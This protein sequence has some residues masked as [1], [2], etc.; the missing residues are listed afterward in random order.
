MLLAL[1]LEAEQCKIL[2]EK[3]HISALAVTGL[4]NQCEWVG[5]VAALGQFQ[6]YSLLPVCIKWSYY[7][8]IV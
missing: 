3:V 6:V 4:L 2:N 8:I 1:Q 7:N 5:P